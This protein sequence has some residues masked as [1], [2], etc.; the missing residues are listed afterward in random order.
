VPTDIKLEGDEGTFN[1]EVVFDLKE[2][3]GEVI[4]TRQVVVYRD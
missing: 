4:G 3:Y 1:V 2:L